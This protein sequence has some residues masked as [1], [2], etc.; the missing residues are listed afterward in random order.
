MSKKI[1]AGALGALAFRYV[2]RP[3]PSPRRRR[4]RLRPARGDPERRHLARRPEGRAD[5]RHRLRALRSSIAT[6]DQPNPVLLSLGDVRTSGVRWGGNDHVLVTVTGYEKPVGLK[7]AYNFTRDLIF[8]TNGKLKGW[9]LDNSAESGLMTGLPI[10]KIVHGDKPVAFVA[11]L[12][13]N[14]KTATNNTRFAED[15]S[16]VRRR[17]RRSTSPV[18]AARSSSAL[19][20][21]TGPSTPTASSAARST[22]SRAS[23][24]A[25]ATTSAPTRSSAAA[26]ASRGWKAMATV[27]SRDVGPARLQRPRGRALLGAGGRRQGRR[28][29]P[30]D[31]LQGRRDDGRARR[32]R[33]RRRRH[34]VRPRQRRAARRHLYDRR[35]PALPVARAQVRVRPRFPEQAVQGQERRHPRLVDRPHP[36]HRARLEPRRAGRLVPVRPGPQGGLGARRGVPGAQGRQLRAA[37]PSSATR[38]ATG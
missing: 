17:C 32:R 24:S 1:M 3:P 11:G 21:G 29:N 15:H 33:G 14:A 36:L 2:R 31:Q 5:Q 13:A 8:D 35:R 16:I 30:Q 10:Y 37:R 18:A 4:R 22:R 34:E 26:R 12:D 25:S 9:L 23:T 28:P 6:L 20:P 38:R 19:A 27:K 7:Y